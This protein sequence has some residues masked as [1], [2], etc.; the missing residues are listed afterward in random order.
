MPGAGRRGRADPDEVPGP[1]PARRGGFNIP[2]PGPYG[3]PIPPCPTIPYG[4]PIP[5]GPV[6]K[7][8]G[9]GLND[10]GWL[11]AASEPAY[12]CVAVVV[13]VLDDDWVGTLPPLGAWGWCL[14]TAS[15]H[16][17]NEVPGRTRGPRAT[18]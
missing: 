6:P 2:G 8:G 1:G 11:A 18:A 4:F 15:V 17:A 7:G 13:L 9:A 16:L 5:G 3:L 12:G 10:S 14:W